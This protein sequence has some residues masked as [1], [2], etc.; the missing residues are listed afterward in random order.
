MKKTK[1]RILSV[2]LAIITL[3][4]LTTIAGAKASRPLGYIEGIPV[5]AKYDLTV[6]E[7]MDIAP[8]KGADG[9]SAWYMGTNDYSVDVYYDEDGVYAEE[10]FAKEEGV[11]LMEVVG[12]KYYSEYVDGDWEEYSEIIEDYFVIIAVHPRKGDYDLGE[13]TYTY[14]DDIKLNYKAEDYAWPNVETADDD[15]AYFS[16]YFV[17]HD[18]NAAD[19]MEDGYIYTFGTGTDNCTC[20]V[21]DGQGNIFENDFTITAKYSFLQWLIRIF[22]FGF[23]WY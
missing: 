4:S 6:G 12:Y 8:I 10:F 13:V 1:R 17:N 21:V 2:V 11:A 3:L 15:G 23:I 16:A 9:S 5:K 20:Y 7:A 18:Y 19:L 22:L 14:M